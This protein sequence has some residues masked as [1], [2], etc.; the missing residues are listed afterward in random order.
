MPLMIGR[1]EIDAGNVAQQ[2][3]GVAGGGT[4]R[5]ERLVCHVSGRRWRRFDARTA[6]DY[7]IQRMR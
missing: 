7:F 4:H 1:L 2:A 6:D 5:G 3:G